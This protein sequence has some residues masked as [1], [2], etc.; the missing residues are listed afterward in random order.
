MGFIEQDREGQRRWALGSAS[1]AAQEAAA[2]VP[3]LV[4]DAAHRLQLRLVG[5]PLIPVAELTAL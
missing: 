4:A 2:F 3:L 5:I 1:S